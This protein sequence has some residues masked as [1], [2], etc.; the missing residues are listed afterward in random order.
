[1]QFEH[2]VL[3]SDIV[4]SLDQWRVMQTWQSPYYQNIEREGIVRWKNVPEPMPS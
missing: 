2:N 4:R 1:M 3:I